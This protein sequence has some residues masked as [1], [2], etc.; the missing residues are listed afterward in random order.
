MTLFGKVLLGII[1]ATG[2]GLLIKSSISP[3]DN[4]TIVSD[5]TPEAV[6]SDAD[7]STPMAGN[8]SGSMGELI[9]RGGNYKC[10]FT[11]TTDAGDSS[12]TTYISGKKIRGD[13]TTNV[14]GVSAM[15]IET[16][17]IS[18]GEFAYTWSSMMPTGMKMKL[19]LSETSDGAK[20]GFDYNQHLDY[21]CSP[22]MEDSSMFSL[23]AN[24]K[25][26]ELPQA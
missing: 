10:D 20:T 18:D 19:N 5:T 6:N 24:I 12:G 25:F 11:H 21:N 14:T 2:A 4:S 7:T 15:K 13:F 1:L 16:H 23:P 8:F 3:K 9:A 26:T 22:W 17:M